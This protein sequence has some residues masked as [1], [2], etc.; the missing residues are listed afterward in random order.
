MFRKLALFTALSVLTACS[1][2]KEDRAKPRASSLVE[3]FGNRTDQEVT[4]ELYGKLSKCM[5]REGFNYPS[6]ESSE[7]QAGSATGFGI[8]DSLLES[9]AQ[10]GRVLAGSPPAGTT[11]RKAYDAALNSCLL[12]PT[13]GSGRPNI[14][15]QLTKKYYGMRARLNQ[16]SRIK[17]MDL[18]WSRC[19]KQAGFA[20]A[21][22][23]SSVISDLFIP[24]QKSLSS[25]EGSAFP[26]SA[27]L[28]G[29]KDLELKMKKTSQNCDVGSFRQ[30][31]K[32]ALEYE[33]SFL[34]EN[35]DLLNAAR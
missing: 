33:A 31:T 6:Q 35:Q 24:L 27:D 28:A 17:K 3:F 7:K 22:R 10:E 8:V 19:M 16:D 1:S 23:F 2:Q 14:S 20:K 11:E 32:I 34:D 18:K 29:L 30:R 21:T 4:K 25:E 5:K 15:P 9:K 13:P 26:S 12:S